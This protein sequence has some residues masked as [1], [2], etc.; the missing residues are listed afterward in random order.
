MGK[1][2]KI[3]VG[4]FFSFYLIY[5]ARPSIYK[6]IKFDLI[7]PVNEKLGKGEYA[8]A[9]DLFFEGIGKSFYEI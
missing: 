7:K 2:S 8:S 6:V 1:V 3:F 9:F 5:T 4:S